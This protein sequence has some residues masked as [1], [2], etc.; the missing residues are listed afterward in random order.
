[1]KFL[2]LF[3]LT[4]FAYADEYIH[5]F[6]PPKGKRFLNISSNPLK[7]HFQV[8]G[9]LRPLFILINGEKVQTKFKKRQCLNTHELIINE[10]PIKV[11]SQIRRFFKEI[12]ID[13]KVNEFSIVYR[14]NKQCYSSKVKIKKGIFNRPISKRIIQDAGGERSYTLELKGDFQ[15]GEVLK[16]DKGKL[17]IGENQAHY[18]VLLKE[19]KNSITGTYRPLFGSE[20][21]LNLPVFLEFESF[22]SDSFV[23]SLKNNYP[24]KSK[25]V[26]VDNDEVTI[27]GKANPDLDLFINGD[28]VAVNE[29]GDFIYEYDV[30]KLS[31]ELNFKIKKGILEKRFSKVIKFPTKKIYPPWYRPRRIKKDKFYGVFS[32][33][34]IFWSKSRFVHDT[35]LQERLSPAFSIAKKWSDLH[36]YE[37]GVRFL[38]RISYFSDTRN[39]ETYDQY[40]LTFKKLFESDHGLIYGA[41]LGLKFGKYT[42]HN[43]DTNLSQSTQENDSFQTFTLDFSVEKRF[44]LYKKFYLHPK[45]DYILPLGLPKR[46]ETWIFEVLPLR[47]GYEF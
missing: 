20:N 4:N 19:G 46:V 11:E 12:V 22:N 30:D 37:F 43:F 31:Q 23:L 40:Y 32:L 10:R 7:S 38:D 29:K 15:K 8:T 41:G 18:S 9:T 45:L 17:N 36:F 3:F 1:M 24:W 16:V 6:S 35:R 34:S 5:F 13:P 47:F 26:I 44:R 14:K 21:V 27:I 33:N 28:E 42:L 25:E 2:L 39:F